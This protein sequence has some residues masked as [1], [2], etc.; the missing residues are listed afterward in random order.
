MQRLRSLLA[1][2]ATG[3]PGNAAGRLGRRGERAAARAL[4]CRGYRLLA[5]NLRTP[6]G[7][8]DLLALA[9]GAVVLV[10]VKSGRCAPRE[11]LEARLRPP[12]RRRL[13][14]AARWLR[15]RPALRPYRFRIDLVTVAFDGRRPVVTIR[16]GISAS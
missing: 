3:R 13:R 8:I 5:R 2:L 1:R 9:D 11:V 16:R 10:E 6:A 14:A 15:R 12:Q 7:E 4:K